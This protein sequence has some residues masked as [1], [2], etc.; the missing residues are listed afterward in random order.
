MRI[1]EFKKVL[2]SYLLNSQL[3]PHFAFPARRTGALAGGR[4]P[5]L[6][7]YISLGQQRILFVLALFLLGVLTFKFYYSSPAPSEEIIKEWVIEVSGEVENPGIYIFQKPPTI[8]E[9]IEQSGGMK[10]PALFEKNSLAEVLETGT[11]LHARKES[12][13]EI[14]IKMER[15]EANKLLVFSIPLDLNRVSMEDLC[16]IP[17]I[18]ESLA[19]EIVTYRER[20]KG[21]RSVEELKNVKGIGEKKYESF[22]TFFIVRH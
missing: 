13:Q 21:F 22:K 3:I 10:E 15:M 6:L 20:R 1:L 14:K 9:A 16:L 19:R 5:Q 8:K 12:S 17:G 11:K 7:K 2:K 4:I 18:G